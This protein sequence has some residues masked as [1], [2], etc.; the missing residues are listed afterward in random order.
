[1]AGITPHFNY[2][3]IKCPD[4]SIT[5][6]FRKVHGILL[7]VSGNAYARDTCDLCRFFAGAKP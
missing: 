1:M 6:T 3:T 5:G 2:N 7:P 4:T